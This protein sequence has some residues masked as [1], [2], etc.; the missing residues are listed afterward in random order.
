M[1][2]I[3]VVCATLIALAGGLG[4]AVYRHVSTPRPNSLRKL[5]GPPVRTLFGNHLFVLECV[6]A[7]Y[8]LLISAFNHRSTSPSR[9]PKIH[10]RLV[11]KYGRNVRI[12][13]FG[14]V[15]AFDPP[16]R[17]QLSGLYHSG[18]TVS[19]PSI[20]SLCLTCS[21]TLPSMRNHGSRVD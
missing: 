6:L 17:I 3:V 8:R 20:L 14:P 12:R 18:M 16:V 15:G 19:F 4:W 21:R 5:A 10:A 2:L 13:G 9:S 7:F 11:E 1:T